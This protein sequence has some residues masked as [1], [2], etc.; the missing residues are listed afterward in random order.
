M[1]TPADRGHLRVSGLGLELGDFALRAVDLVAAKGE[2]H[3]LLGPS[4]SGKSTLMRCILGQHRAGSGSITLG[5]R[6]ITQLPPERRRMGYVPQ[7]Y[8]LFPHLDVERNV[9][10]G[11]AAGR[12]TSHEASARVDR[13]C[14]LL[15]IENL[16]RRRVDFLSGGERQKVALARALVTRPE[17]IMLDEPFSSI[18]EGS[19]RRLWFELK[20]V[21]TELGVTALHITH[22]IEEACVMGE[23]MSVLVEGRIAQCGTSRD[24]LERPASVAVATYL[25]YRNIFAGTAG[26]HPDGAAVQL[27]GFEVVLR[28]ELSS[29]EHVRVCARPQDIKIVKAGV[30]VRGTLS[31][32]VFAGSFVRLFPTTDACVAW[33]QLEGSDQP[34][35]FE[36]RFPLYIKD[37]HELELGKP[38]SVA[39]HE[40]ALVVFRD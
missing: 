12:V 15:G 8:A 7:N 5:G 1:P 38:V 29:G 11:L 26:P 17:A 39:F 13:I 24:L 9:R 36:L 21:M 37:R 10:F 14:G 2:Y 19:R 25:G 23:R 16:R 34:F 20:N 40:P 33:F 31:G 4:G 35:D 22:S 28:R 6:D 18:D 32:N 30:P 27:E 3:I